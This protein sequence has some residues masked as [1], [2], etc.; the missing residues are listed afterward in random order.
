MVSDEEIV[1]LRNINNQ[2]E[3]KLEVARD[4]LEFYAKSTQD[5]WEYFNIMMSDI[6]K[7]G[8]HKRATEALA[9]IEGK[10]KQDERR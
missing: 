10:V 4:A 2:L 1:T 5:S 8:S 7:D 9:I 6:N 3:K